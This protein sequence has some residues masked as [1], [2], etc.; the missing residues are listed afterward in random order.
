[1]CDTFFTDYHW[2]PDFLDESLV[3]AGDRSWEVYYGNDIYGRGTYGGGVF[4]TH[5]ALNE[6]CQRPLSIAL[7]GQAYFYQNLNGWRNELSFRR[8]EEQFWEGKH[9]LT[10]KL[11]N[12]TAGIKHLDDG[13]ISGAGKWTYLEGDFKPAKDDVGECIVSTHM[14]CK[15]LYEIQISQHSKE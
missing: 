12:E 10:F 6:I 13:S 4:N 11:D 3:F 2:R 14:W 7:F 1:M 15:R 8:N 9:V 5:V